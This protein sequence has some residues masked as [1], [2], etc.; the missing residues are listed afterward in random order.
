MKNVGNYTFFTSLSY[1]TLFWFIFELRVQKA[2][3]KVQKERLKASS[4]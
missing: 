4:L 2:K 3:L 1:Y